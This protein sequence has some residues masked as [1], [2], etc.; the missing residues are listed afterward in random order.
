MKVFSI[1]SGIINL[2]L[3]ETIS[4]KKGSNGYNLKDNEPMNEFY[5]SFNFQSGREIILDAM[6]K[7]ELEKA[8][9][10]ICS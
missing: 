5:L 1:K 4:I 7:D 8:L 3:V 10:I 6:N 2:D 9:Q